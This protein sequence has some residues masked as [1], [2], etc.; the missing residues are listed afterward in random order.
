LILVKR[1]LWPPP[2]PVEAPA[3]WTKT[4]NQRHKIAMGVKDFEEQVTA[5]TNV[6][7]RPALVSGVVIGMPNA[8]ASKA[9]GTDFDHLDE[10]DVRKSTERNEPVLAPNIRAFNKAPLSSL[11]SK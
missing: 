3:A 4:P 11:T 2:G 9:N 10:R 5:C 7:R 1:G 6:H 8:T